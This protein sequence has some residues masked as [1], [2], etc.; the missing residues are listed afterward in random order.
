MRALVV[1][2]TLLCSSLAAAQE[3]LAGSWTV[4]VTE[5]G[6]GTCV[7]NPGAV[8]AYVWI[9]STQPDGTVV[10]SVQ[11]QTPFPVMG[12][13]LEGDTL[14]LQAYANVKGRTETTWIRL[15]TSPLEMVGVRRHLSIQPQKFSKK[16][17]SAPCFLDLDVLAK[18]NN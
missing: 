13:K 2:A 11:G 15:K 14:T 6:T 10:V 17:V 4:T 9:V 7:S 16:T 18:K 1:L 8:T 12:G 5:T 3:G